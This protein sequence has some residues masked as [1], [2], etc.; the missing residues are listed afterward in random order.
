MLQ[1]DTYEIIIYL[2][3]SSFKWIAFLAVRPPYA[4]SSNSTTLAKAQEQI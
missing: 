3:L 2:F 1:Y 4:K